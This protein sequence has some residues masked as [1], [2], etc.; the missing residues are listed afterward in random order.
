MLHVRHWLQWAVRQFSLPNL[1]LA[2][3]NINGEQLFNLTLQDFQ[4]LVPYDPDDI[5][6][7]HLELLR[8]MKVVGEL[9]KSVRL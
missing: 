1:K 6:W 2:D 3:W 8:K 5:F 4:K 7:T 9:I